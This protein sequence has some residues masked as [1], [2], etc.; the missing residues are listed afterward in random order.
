VSAT[1][2]SEKTS[3][4]MVM[5]PPATTDSVERAP[6][7]S[8]SG[9]S[10]T[11]RTARCSSSINW[12]PSGAA[13]PKIAKASGSTQN[14]SNRC[15]ILPGTSRRMI[16]AG[17]RS[18]SPAFS[19][20]CGSRSATRPLRALHLG[21]TRGGAREL[22]RAFALGKDR[23]RGGVGR[24]VELYPRLVEGIDQRHQPLRLVVPGRAEARHVV[25][26]EHPKV[27]GHR[28]V[29]GGA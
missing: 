10:P 27:P 9:S 26:E 8:I 24:D 11:N 23:V 25:E 21:E 6:S 19:R 14:A 16:S 12:R 3:D 22:E 4:V 7:T 29:V 20:Q 1:K 17:L 13:M 28:Q 15:C 5:T 2:A 18:A